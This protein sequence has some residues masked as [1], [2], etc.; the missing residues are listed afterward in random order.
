MTDAD[1]E[2]VILP[3]LMS[4]RDSAPHAFVP[5]PAAVIARA[6]RRRTRRRAAAG[7]AL[8]AALLLGAGA[9]L[10]SGL[11]GQGQQVV[12]IT[13]PTS[14]RYEAP[15]KVYRTASPVYS[16][17]T[18]DASVQ[19]GDLGPS[20]AMTSFLRTGDW[21]AETLWQQ[22][23]S[24]AALSLPDPPLGGASS[25][26][27]LLEDG[28]HPVRQEIFSAYTEYAARAMTRYQRLIGS[29]GA[30]TSHGIPVTMT[31]AGTGFAGEESVLLSVTT[32]AGSYWYSFVRQGE[33]ISQIK[34]D[35]DQVTAIAIAIKAAARLCASTATC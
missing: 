13:G 34:S 22:C 19:P 10:V 4:Y 28:E 32:G 5:P 23:P 31:V 6:A 33:M 11:P 27:I 1:Q 12:P 16:E 18:S 15:M 17:L 20:Y 21:L 30:F 3:A 9:A 24:Y 8:A 35:S 14:E 26:E 29:C 25:R 7:T 2:L